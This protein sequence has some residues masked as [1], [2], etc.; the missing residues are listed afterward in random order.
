MSYYYKTD[1]NLADEDIRIN[2]QFQ[3]QSFCFQSNAG[4]FSKDKIDQG[5]I[6]LLEYLL[7]LPLAGKLM[8]VGC[9]YGVLGIVAKRFFPQL[10]VSLV[11]IN[12]RAVTATMTNCRKNMIDARVFHS[13]L[14]SEICD[15]YDFI[16]SNPPIR[17]GKKV[18]L[19][20][21]EQA[22]EHLL[23]AGCLLLVVRKQQGALSLAKFIETSYGNCQIAKRRQGYCVL[24]VDK[25]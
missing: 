12:Q 9:G 4:I 11:D 16:I 14:F 17:A 6:Y 10:E 3:G 24:R 8:D 13:D 23:P 25:A 1:D 18:V 22:I 2:W 15:K 5:S 20:L 19:Q 21:V 7:S